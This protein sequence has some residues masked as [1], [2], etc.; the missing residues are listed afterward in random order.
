MLEKTHGYL[1]VHA[2][3]H[4]I[5][6]NAIIVKHMAECQTQLEPES[7]AAVQLN[8]IGLRQMEVGGG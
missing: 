2:S 7:L 3:A 8:G 4:I 6:G 5:Q 1:T